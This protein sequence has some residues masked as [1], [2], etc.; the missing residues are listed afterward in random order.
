[1]SLELGKYKY[2]LFVAS[3]FGNSAI[4]RLLA[5]IHLENKSQNN[6]QKIAEKPT[7]NRLEPE[8]PHTNASTEV[9]EVKKAFPKFI[10]VRTIGRPTVPALEPGIGRGRDG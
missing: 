4:G 9:K 1:L 5:K 8:K 6:E 7:S 10:D 3:S 2:F